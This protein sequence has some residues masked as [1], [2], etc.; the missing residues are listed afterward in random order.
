MPQVKE[1]QDEFVELEKE[2]LK[3]RCSLTQANESISQLTKQN[4][5]LEKQLSKFHRKS[6]GCKEQFD[7]VT[8]KLC[9]KDDALNTL[10]YQYREILNR[11]NQSEQDYDELVDQVSTLKQTIAT[12]NGQSV[13]QT[14]NNLGRSLNISLYCVLN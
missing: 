3:N 4:L 11:N 6:Y 7:E 5:E 8:K 13:A 9:E 12:L 14:E 2:L 10:Q 1:Y